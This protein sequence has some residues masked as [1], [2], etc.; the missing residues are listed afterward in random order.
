MDLVKA[1]LKSVRFPRTAAEGLRQCMELSE[2]ARHWFLESIRSEWPA[3][4]EEGIENERRLL[5]ARFS[6]GDDR[7]AAKWKKERDRYFRK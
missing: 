2:I 1:E 6:A 4:S 3:A 7:R 5:F